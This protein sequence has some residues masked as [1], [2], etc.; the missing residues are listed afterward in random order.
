MDKYTQKA[1]EQ[2]APMKEGM[3]AL[4][5]YADNVKKLA[6]GFEEAERKAARER[7]SKL[8][9]AVQVTDIK[10]FI[11]L[12]VDLHVSV[13]AEG[14][15]VTLIE[16]KVATKRASGSARIKCSDFPFPVLGE[17]GQP[18]G[19]TVTFKYWKDACIAHGLTEEYFNED[20]DNGQSRSGHREYRKLYE[21]TLK[22]LVEGAPKA[23]LPI[24]L[25]IDNDQD[26]EKFVREPVEAEADESEADDDEADE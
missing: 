3:E 24:G 2:L 16:R 5:I 12:E 4:G 19:K 6:K 1:Q 25:M 22:P 7:A 17:D 15:K 9:E 26:V 23:G 18:T 21:G 14:A 20:A 13:T 10:P 8:L 11:G